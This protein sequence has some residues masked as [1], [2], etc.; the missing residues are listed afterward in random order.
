MQFSELP[1]AF[2]TNLYNK[3]VYFLYMFMAIPGNFVDLL[4]DYELLVINYCK[5]LLL[6]TFSVLLFAF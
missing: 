4:I 1:M 6:I 2:H 3:K 5:L